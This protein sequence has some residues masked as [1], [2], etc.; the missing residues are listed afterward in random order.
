MALLPTG[1]GKSICYQIPALLKP[2]V[3]LVVSPLIALMH[4][5][6]ANLQKRGIKAIAITS[7]MSKK[8]IDIQL[9]N[10]I[11]GETKL[12]YV[13]PERLKTHLFLARF[14]KMNVNLIAVDEAHCISQWGYDFRPAYLEI[15]ELRKLKPNVPILAL[16]ATATAKVV[17]DIQN[18][19]NFV[20]GQVIQKSFFRSNL[21]YATF[22]VANKKNHIE[23]FL[24]I[25]Q[26]SGIIYCATRKGVKDLA[27]YLFS[28]HVAVDYYHAGLSFE[29]RKEKQ[30]NWLNEK[31]RVIVCTNA[32]GMGIDKPNVRFVLHYDIPE[33]IEA[34]FQE[35]GRAGRDEKPA[36]A[37]LYYEEH[38]INLL[39][40]KVQ[41]K[42]PPVEKIKSIYNAL[43]N[44]FQLAF[45]AGKG[46][47][48]PFEI[49]DFCNRYNHK[50]IDVYNSIKFLESCN[51]LELSE[52]AY[53]PSKIRI[54]ANQMQLYQLQVKETA[55]NTLIQ[56]L[57]R[58]YVGILDDYV[59]IS[60]F[61]VAQK[62]KLSKK[63]IAEKL[64][65]L[66]KMEYADY[67]AQSDQPRITYLSERLPDDHLIFEPRFYK[68]RKE[69]AFEKMKAMVH[70]LNADECRSVLLLRYFGEETSEECGFC[71][72]CL[73]KKQTA[74][75]EEIFFAIKKFIE[76][77]SKE[78]QVI[79]TQV[80]LD[81]FHPYN[82]SQVM[83]CLRELADLGM[84]R[85]EESGKF[86][87]KQ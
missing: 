66:H 63:E 86:F 50:I 57:L 23:S 38:D 9:D 35:A 18:K 56:F 1:G 6:V 11:Y 68:D 82:K 49:N 60:E 26:G 14:Q 4:D 70:Y 22:Q 46:E 85:F 79:A 61:I 30:E 42:Y 62:T 48:F 71:P 2:G 78:K 58:S 80:V 21:T 43:G 52:G 67:V 41:A 74:G 51:Y 29:E 28:K 10:V 45:G 44:Y 64:M 34:Y 55:M 83:D 73:Q 37:H 32:F 13:S 33:N 77:I 27:S 76:Q 87:E 59:S 47:H 12:L 31:T 19:L 81:K 17:S 36:V 16:T 39:I 65:Q 8:Q 5:Q 75:K 84:I 20:S 72:V 40:E 3:C 53:T 25:N 69:L 24:R 7:G 54:V 15:A